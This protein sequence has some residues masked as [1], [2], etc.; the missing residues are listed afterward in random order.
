MAPAWSFLFS[1]NG[2]K[3]NP[4]RLVFN[5]KEG[6]ALNA[7]VI[8]MGNRFCLLVNEMEAVNPRHDFPKF[9]VARVLWKRLP[10][11]QTACT[12]WILAGGA[13]HTCYSQ[14]FN[15]RTSA[16]FCRDVRN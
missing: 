13:H 1:I 6:T 14:K 9:P 11:L 8:D 4:V 7:S 2:G 12:A 5:V 16:G 15:F 10:D 3:A